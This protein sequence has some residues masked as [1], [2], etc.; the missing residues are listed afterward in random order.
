MTHPDLKC[1]DWNTGF[2]AY[3]AEGYTKV[4]AA[5]MDIL[6]GWQRQSLLQKCLML[7]RLSIPTGRTAVQFLFQ[8]GYVGFILPGER[9]QGQHGS[10]L[11]STQQSV[12]K[13]QG[14]FKAFIQGDG[15]Q[16]SIC[17]SFGDGGLISL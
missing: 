7:F 6:P 15:A 2:I 17:L 5:N 9:C 13:P 3:G 4:V 14:S 1:L 12:M 10:I 16:G 11:F 8:E